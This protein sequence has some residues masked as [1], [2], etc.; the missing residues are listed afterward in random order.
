MCPSNGKGEVDFVVPRSGVPVPIQ[1]T[2]DAPSERHRLALDE[3]YEAHPHA[4]EAVF[5][6]PE[7]FAAGLP[8]LTAT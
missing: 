2:I 4:A 6:T 5:V 7:S 3:F 1:V 8:E